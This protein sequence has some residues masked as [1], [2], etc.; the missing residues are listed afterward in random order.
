MFLDMQIEEVDTSHAAVDLAILFKDED[1]AWR[2]DIKRLCRDIER[3]FADYY[4]ERQLWLLRAYKAGKLSFILYKDKIAEVTK[5]LNRLA[6][7]SNLWEK[8]YEG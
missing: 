4:G 7:T 3:M 5:N 2:A 1:I 6:E 8:V